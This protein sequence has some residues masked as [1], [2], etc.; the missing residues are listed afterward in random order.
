MAER[1]EKLGAVV[2]I[3][4]L[5]VTVFWN[6]RQDE[7]IDRQEDEQFASTVYVGEAPQYYYD[8]HGLPTEEALTGA[9][10]ALRLERLDP[11]R[12]LEWHLAR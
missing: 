1:W 3:G 4:T 10:D 7:R 9:A 8:A 5:G 12:V 2:A 6:M 11:D